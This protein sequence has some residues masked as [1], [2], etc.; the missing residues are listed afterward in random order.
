MMVRLLMFVGWLAMLAVSALIA[1]LG[2][3]CVAVV[4]WF[5]WAALTGSLP[6]P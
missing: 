3:V 4:F 1:L 5:V 6:N 2:W